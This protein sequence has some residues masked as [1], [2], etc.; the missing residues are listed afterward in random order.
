MSEHLLLFYG[1]AL[2]SVALV[3]TV[4]TH[5]PYFALLVLLWWL[6]DVLANVRADDAAEV[7]FFAPACA[8]LG[9]VT[10]LDLL[11]LFGTWTFPLLSP[12]PWRYLFTDRKS[13]STDN[14]T[15][16]FII[17]NFPTQLFFLALLLGPISINFLRSRF[18][19]RLIESS[20]LSI[21]IGVILLV[22]AIAIVLV[23]FAKWFSD[24]QRR[25]NRLTI[26]YAFLFLLWV[27]LPPVVL[28]LTLR[29]EVLCFIVTEALLLIL[30]G[31]TA[32][33]EIPQINTPLAPGESVDSDLRYYVASRLTTPMN[34]LR[35][36]VL[37]YL[38]LAVLC[39]LMLL[40]HRVSTLVF[41]LT[42]FVSTLTFFAILAT[43]FFARSARGNESVPSTFASRTPARQSDVESGGNGRGASTTLVPSTASNRTQHNSTGNNTSR[44]PPQK[45][46]SRGEST[47]SQ[48][49][50]AL[51]IV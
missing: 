41:A 2:F 12:K 33:L 16:I 11:W 18:S 8:V 21:V 3:A 29:N 42:I 40:I 27:L 1:F 26:L 6:P 28:R 14:R 17:S 46:S 23:V 43:F 19:P 4:F 36:F 48:E 51:S 30:F 7:L 22:T 20:T 24:R 38:P 47:I 44:I 10:A 50:G 31:L 45:S 34:L 32:L 37:L 5:S 39:I 35:N 49:L 9:V 15:S 25:T 13:A